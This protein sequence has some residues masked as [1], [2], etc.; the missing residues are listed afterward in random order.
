M[1]E[2][3]KYPPVP[4]ASAALPFEG[5]DLEKFGVLARKSLPWAAL[6]IAGTLTVSYLYLRWTKPMYESE[7]ELKL[8]IKSEASEFGISAFGQA[9]AQNNI[10]GEI[11]I[12]RSKLFF[13]K[14][15]NAVDI[16]VSYF[17]EGKVLVEEKYKVSPFLV[18]YHLLRNPTLYNTRI[19]IEMKNASK[20]TLSYRNGNEERVLHGTFGERLESEDMDVTITLTKN[21]NA[22]DSNP[23]YFIIN[24]RDA[25]LN[26]LN[27]KLVVQPVNMQ[28]NTIRIAYRDHNK[29]KAYDLVNAIDTLYVQYSDEEKKRANKQKIDWL[30]GELEQIEDRMEGYEGFME[31]MTIQNRSANLE[32]DLAATISLINTLDSTRYQYKVRLENID[33]LV[34]SLE[35]EQLVSL[36]EFKRSYYPN[37]IVESVEKMH[38]LFRDKERISMSYNENTFVYQRRVGEITATKDRLISQLRGMQNQWNLQLKELNDRRAKLETQFVGL[39]SKNTQF[40]KVQRFYKLYEG[41]YLSLM[42]NK[43]QFEVANAGTT[44]DYKI[45][46]SASMPYAPIY[47]KP[48][49][50]Y[51]LGLVAGLFFSF[52]MITLRYVI[53]HTIDSVGEVERLIERIPLVGAIPKAKRKLGN[54]RLIIT[55]S[56][57]SA[58]S[59]AFR[60]IRTNIEFMMAG[61]DK[62]I[63]SVTSTSGGEGKTFVS[64]N[65][66]T[67]MAM[68]RKKVVVVDLDMRKPRIHETFGT[69][70]E[71]KG[72]ST[73]LIDRY[74]LKECI[75]HSQIAG[76]DFVPA[77]PIPPN[78]SELLASSAF[79][80]LLAELKELYDV[81]IMDTPPI[82][83]VTDGILAMSKA[84]LTLYVIRANY[85]DKSFVK[86]LQRVRTNLN[87][88]AIGIVFNA[89]DL[90]GAKKNGYGYYSDN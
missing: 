1:P 32:R 87:Y 55:I 82:G 61:Q 37:D 56:P 18:K 69:E 28:A 27:N 50:V 85:S 15:L 66:A 71:E 17:A 64:S 51:G 21:Y 75:V 26:M 36:E 81:I 67:V 3:G 47:P 86:T 34:Q 25:L 22:N 20:Y 35:K 83:L 73:V 70:N 78:P 33:L 84:D 23:Y 52:L 40:S 72:L 24:S 39:P 44:P 88:P 60:S 16:E 77:G 13:Q 7:S 89:E 68:S 38:E 80:Q 63:I 11:E 19:N 62:R 29:L 53:N 43:A 10:S 79:D 5:I 8:D 2:Q 45:L 30:N 90:T 31:N 76:L 4:P 14:V 48:Y 42:Q 46:S 57:K 6:L 74:P 54:H 65:L 49:L 58:T 59:E 9:Q 12:I 41:L